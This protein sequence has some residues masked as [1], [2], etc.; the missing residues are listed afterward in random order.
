LERPSVPQMLLYADTILGILGLLFSRPFS[1]WIC[2]MHGSW[3]RRRIVFLMCWVLISG[4]VVLD[5]LMS[6]YGALSSYCGFAIALQL[7]FFALSLLG[8]LF[9]SVMLRAF[10]CFGFCIH[11]TLW[12]AAIVPIMNGSS[13]SALTQQYPPIA[14]ALPRALSSHRFYLS[15]LLQFMCALVFSVWIY[16]DRVTFAAVFR[17][18]YVRLSGYEKMAMH[19]ANIASFLPLFLVWYYL[20]APPSISLRLIVHDFL[21]SVSHALVCSDFGAYP[22]WNTIILVGAA[23]NCLLLWLLTSVSSLWVGFPM[24]MW[25]GRALIIQVA[26][27]MRI[28]AR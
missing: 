14:S 24:W 15:F 28:A 11:G 3:R 1:L 13:L 26:A 19:L 22:P 2:R 10:R 6:G 5:S 9:P 4:F 12:V 16:L 23:A 20:F 8:S 17:D 21:V 27:R 25:N 7:C 18:D